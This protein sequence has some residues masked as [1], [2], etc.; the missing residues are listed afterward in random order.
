MG[1]AVLANMLD[2]TP[3]VANGIHKSAVIAEDVVL[4]DNVSVGAN[5]VI[6]SGVQ[7]AR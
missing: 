7:L 5:T 2:S 1:Y 6:E 3:K 4:G